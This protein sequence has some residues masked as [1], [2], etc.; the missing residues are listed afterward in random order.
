MSSLCALGRIAQSVLVIDL[1]AG[2]LAEGSDSV[3]EPCKGFNG[4]E[5][6]VVRS[7]TLVLIESVGGDLLPV[8]L[9]EV[10]ANEGESMIRSVIPLPAERDKVVSAS[11]ATATRNPDGDAKEA[12]FID[13]IQ[14]TYSDSEEAE[15][16]LIGVLLGLIYL[17]AV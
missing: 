12:S 10:L 1:E 7:D 3:G 8:G 6:D 4:D 17:D 15:N 2:D 9:V 11:G 5:V 16:R 14:A 13:G